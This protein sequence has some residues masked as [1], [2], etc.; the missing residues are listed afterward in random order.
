MGYCTDNSY[1]AGAVCTMCVFGR[2]GGK[3]RG[4]PCTGEGFLL[5]CFVKEDGQAALVWHCFGYEAQS[6]CQDTVLGGK[7]G[8]QGT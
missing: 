8:W 7:L 1:P 2:G 5:L 4:G 6:C 3:G